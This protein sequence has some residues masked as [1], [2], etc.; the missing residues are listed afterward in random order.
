MIVTVNGKET[1]LADGVSVLDLLKSR[2]LA[3]DTVVVELNRE[4]VLAD[5]YGATVLSDGDQL[6]VLRFVGGG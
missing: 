5:R 3:P 6:E 4:I 2:K 1:D